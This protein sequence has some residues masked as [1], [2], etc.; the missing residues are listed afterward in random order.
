MNILYSTIDRHT[1]GYDI[2]DVESPFILNLPIRFWIYDNNRVY[3][4][5]IPKDFKSD[6]ATITMKLA[7]FIIGC[8]HNPLFFPSV[9]AHDYMCCHKDRYSRKFASDVM[10]QLLL[11]RGVP[12]WKSYLMYYCVE[13]YQK[14]W[15]CWE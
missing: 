10:L 5:T 9:L 2:Y 14:Y 4:I 1:I 3:K 8:E 7:K 15:E 6:G 13:L 11:K 12:K